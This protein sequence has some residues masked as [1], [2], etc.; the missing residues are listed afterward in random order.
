MVSKQPSEFSRL[1]ASLRIKSG[2]SRYWIA[3]YTHLTESYIYRLETGEKR[4]PSEPVVA[5]LSLALAAGCSKITLD[6]I[7]RLRFAAGYAP[8][9]TRGEAN[10]ES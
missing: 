3:R 5:K 1:F 8:L 6:D 10:W 9:Q 4:K 2:K 7:N